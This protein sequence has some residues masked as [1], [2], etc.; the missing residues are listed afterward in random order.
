M[1]KYKN[2]FIMVDRCIFKNTKVFEC[3]SMHLGVFV[4]YFIV[5]V[6]YFNVIQWIY[7]IFQFTLICL[8]V[9]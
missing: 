8:K 6:I 2:V 5:L 9:F 7:S 4:L 3:F 1:L